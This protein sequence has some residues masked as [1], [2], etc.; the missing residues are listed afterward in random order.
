MLAV[1]PLAPLWVG[2][3]L[4]TISFLSGWLMTR[5]I[6]TARISVTA[7]GIHRGRRALSISQSAS[8]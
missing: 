6:R 4:E 1:F 2:W 7:G 8:R 3:T 5:G